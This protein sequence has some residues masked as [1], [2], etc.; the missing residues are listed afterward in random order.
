MDVV[1]GEE[2][3]PA[4]RVHQ[5]LL[6]GLLSHLGFKDV[7]TTANARDK[8]AKAPRPGDIMR[9]PALAATKSMNHNYMPEQQASNNGLMDSFPK[10]TGTAGPPPGAPGARARPGRAAPASPCGRAASARRPACRCAPWRASCSSHERRSRSPAWRRP[11]PASRSDSPPASPEPPAPR[12]APQQQSRRA[13][14][15]VASRPHPSRRATRSGRG[16][17]PERTSRSS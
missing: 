14:V 4:Q 7:L 2:P 3:A 13:E 11:S 9:F 17:D 5:A 8:N 12:R 15:G 16:E 1:L 6:A 10:Y